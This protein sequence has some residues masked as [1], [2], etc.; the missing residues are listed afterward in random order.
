MDFFKRHFFVPLA[1]VLGLVAIAYLGVKV[2]LTYVFGVIIPYLAVL[3]FFEGLI[4]RLISGPGRR[5]PS[6]FPRPAAR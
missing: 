6:R 4:Y 3:I 5:F 1:A 2:N